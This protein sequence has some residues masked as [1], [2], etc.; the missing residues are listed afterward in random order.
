L[1]ATKVSSQSGDESQTFTYESVTYET[2]ADSVF[3]L[4]RKLSRRC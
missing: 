1:V 2:L 4:P 3:E